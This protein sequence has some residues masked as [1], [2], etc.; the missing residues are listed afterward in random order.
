MPRVTYRII[1]TAEGWVIEHDDGSSGGYELPEAA[2][3]AAAAAASLDLKE[4]RDITLSV[5]FPE[6]PED[7][8]ALA[9]NSEPALQRGQFDS[10]TGRTG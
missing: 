10:S 9:G 5:E 1:S 3:E 4:R 7:T 8:E 2:F 6:G